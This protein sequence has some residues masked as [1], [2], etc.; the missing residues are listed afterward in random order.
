MQ[1]MT[2]NHFK[3]LNFHVGNEKAWHALN[4]AQFFS[5]LA[6]VKV[7][8]KDFFVD[9]NMILLIPKKFPKVFSIAPHF[10][11]IC[12]PQNCPHFTCIAKPSISNRN[13]YL[14]EFA[15][16]HFFPFCFLDEPIKMACFKRKKIVELARHFI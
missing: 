6:L 11:R 1:K 2:T 8:R 9:C 16:L 10:Y 13:F 15:K 4:M 14:R 12:F 5:F 3:N 7:L